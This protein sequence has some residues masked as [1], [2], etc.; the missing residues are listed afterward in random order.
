MTLYIIV[1]E[2]TSLIHLTHLKLIKVLIKT[3]LFEHPVS[4]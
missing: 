4:R 2:T 1:E 3:T